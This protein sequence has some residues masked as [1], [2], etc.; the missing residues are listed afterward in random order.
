MSFWRDD[1]MKKKPKGMEVC[2]ITPGVVPH[3]CKRCITDKCPF[4]K[5]PKGKKPKK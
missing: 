1:I 3:C 4:G 2:F 5:K